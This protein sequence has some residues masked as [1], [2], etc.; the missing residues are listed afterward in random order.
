MGNAVSATTGRSLFTASMAKYMNL[1][2]PQVMAVRNIAT[3]LASTKHGSISRRNFQYA[4][5][6]AEVAKT[7]DQE[8]FN[9]L[10]TMWDLNG[11]D[12]VS[13][14]E[15]IIGMSFLACKEDSVEQAIRFALQVADRNRSGMISSKEA[16][17]FMRSK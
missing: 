9:L 16:S 8:V 15:F 13:C 4:L 2:K 6:Q 7:P 1:T 17:T 5:N 10:F 11:T 14:A 3:R 12:R